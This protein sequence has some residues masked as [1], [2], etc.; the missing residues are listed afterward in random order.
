M[1][2]LLGVAIA[3]LAAEALD[4][5]RWGAERI[6]V[7]AAQR[8][9]DRSGIDHT[10]EWLDDLKERPGNILKL[11][12]AVWLA[13]GAIVPPDWLTLNAP[14]LWRAARPYRYTAAEVRAVLIGLVRARVRDFGT[15][16]GL[17][18]LHLLAIRAAASLLPEGQRT[19]FRQEW[20]AEIFAV[21]NRI[22]MG[23]CLSLI[24]G[25]PRLAIFVRFA[26]RRI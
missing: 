13:M 22:R 5:S 26:R 18:R 10:K 17:G 1:E 15:E 23:F 6:V 19:R 3:M 2:V 16:T 4:I 20:E 7:W 21:P 9:K 12:S 24:A 11:L 8:W 14:S 25:A